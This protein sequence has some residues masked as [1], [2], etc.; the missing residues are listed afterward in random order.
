[1]IQIGL[2]STRHKAF[3]YDNTMTVRIRYFLSA[4]IELFM[5]TAVYGFW[6]D[7]VLCYLHSEK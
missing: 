4:S 5:S 1:M 6:L 7:D 3:G 2:V